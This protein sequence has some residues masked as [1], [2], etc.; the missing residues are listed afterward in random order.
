[1]PTP[2][3]IVIISQDHDG[4]IE[5]TS[6]FTAPEWPEFMLNDPVANKYWEK[7]YRLFP[8]YQFV[9][10]DPESEEFLASCNSIPLNWEGDFKGLPDEG[11]DWALRKG[12]EDL[13]AGLQPNIQCALSVTI[14]K[15]YRGQGLSA[16][17]VRAMKKIGQDRGLRHMIAPVR[18]T[19]KH[20][21]PHTPMSSY[22]RWRDSKGIPKD[23]WMR[24]HA[25]EGAKIVRPCLRSMRIVG[26]IDK[27]EEWTGMRFPGNDIYIVPG[28]LAPV[29]INWDRNEGTYI[30]PNVWMVHDL[31]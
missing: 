28:A 20:R 17:A 2:E 22:I 27:W 12:F 15:K 25:K 4:M 7:L 30:E 10:A 6:A 14:S 3:Y 19:L 1:M 24:V 11:W 13:E 16:H 18:P 8:H 26:T 31:T 23:P 5:K 21:Y 29:K 9:L